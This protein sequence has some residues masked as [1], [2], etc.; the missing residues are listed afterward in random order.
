VRCCISSWKL[1]GTGAAGDA[2]V[3][4]GWACSKGTSG[5]YRPSQLS[6]IAAANQSV[7]YRCHLHSLHTRLTFANPRLSSTTV[8]GLSLRD[9]LERASACKDNKRPQVS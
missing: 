6:T 8:S 5:E 7:R 4:K 1:A 3:V 2:Y 9:G